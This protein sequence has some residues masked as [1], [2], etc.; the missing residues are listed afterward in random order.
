MRIINLLPKAKQKEFNSRKVFRSVL[1]L[2]GITGFTFFLI[3]MAQFASRLYMEYEL[4]RIAREIDRIKSVSNKEENAELKKRV[5]G[6]N[7][8][9]TDYNTLA[10]DAPKW[11][12]ALRAFSEV[13]PDNVYIQSFVADVVKRQVA[14][15]G[16]APSRE[17]VI[18]LYN[19][20]VADR[21]HFSSIDYPLENISKPTDVQ[22]RFTFTFEESVLQ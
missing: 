16:F 18:Q 19:N 6:I 7:N 13:I 9:I 21:E 15:Q 20:I 11:S 3:I 5:Q 10:K 12:N 17:S 14:I 22:F 4:Q 8:Q 1:V 2:F